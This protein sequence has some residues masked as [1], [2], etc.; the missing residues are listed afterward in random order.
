MMIAELGQ[1]TDLQQLNVPDVSSPK[2]ESQEE[3]LNSGNLPLYM[4]RNADKSGCV[5][6]RKSNGLENW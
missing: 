5:T 3:F 1:L 4:Q 6:A 2:L